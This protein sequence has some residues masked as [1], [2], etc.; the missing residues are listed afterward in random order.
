MEP[1]KPFPTMQRKANYIK[2]QMIHDVRTCTAKTT[3]YMH[4]SRVTD[5]VPSVT[6]SLTNCRKSTLVS[7][8]CSPIC[9]LWVQF[10]KFIWYIY[11]VKYANICKICVNMCKCV[12]IGQK[13]IFMHFQYYRYIY[14][15]LHINKSRAS[16]TNNG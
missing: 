3:V 14:L 6:C 7:I 4:Q 11:V 10:D 1:Y 15:S 16:G 13:C 9:I 8:L 2:F 5:T 12:Y